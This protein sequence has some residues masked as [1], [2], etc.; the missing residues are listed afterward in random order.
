[1][2]SERSPA[3][4]RPFGRQLRVRLWE[5]ARYAAGGARSRESVRADLLQNDTKVRQG[6]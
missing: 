6:C 4:G 2:V 5:A 1:M 3:G